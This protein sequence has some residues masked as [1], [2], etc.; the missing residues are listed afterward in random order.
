MKWARPKIAFALAAIALLSG[1]FALL[2]S[3]L[4]TAMIIGFGLLVW[5]PRPFADSHQLINWVG[6]AQNLAIAGAAWIV[7]DFL[8]QTRYIT[9]KS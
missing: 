8:E 4:T 7:C 2:A 6:N 9:T 1:W 5:L 3:R